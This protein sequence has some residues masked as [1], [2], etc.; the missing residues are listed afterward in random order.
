MG[1]VEGLARLSAEMVHQASLIS[2]INAFGLYTLASAAAIPL[3]LLV[4]RPP[5]KAARAGA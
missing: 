1:S 3:I 4:S 2:Y 5:S